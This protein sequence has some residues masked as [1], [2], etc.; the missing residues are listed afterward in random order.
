MK[1][2]TASYSIRRTR[3][4]QGRVTKVQEGEPHHKGDPKAYLLSARSGDSKRI[5]S[6]THDANDLPDVLSPV[7]PADNTW[8]GCIENRVDRVYAEVLL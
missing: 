8:R 7:E 3:C 1:G 2:K 5:W 4:L 6:T